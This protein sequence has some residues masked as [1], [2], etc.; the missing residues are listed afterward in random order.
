MHA[1]YHE[2]EEEYP[3]KWNNLISSLKVQAR[4]GKADPII[5]DIVYDSRKVT[6]G[7]VYVS[8][9]G[10]VVHGDQFIA[11]AMEQGAVAVIS[12]NPQLA[13]TVPWIQVENSRIVL[14][15]LARKLWNM[16]LYNTMLVGVTGT[17]GKTTVA[18]LY[19]KLL[20]EL[21]RNKD[22]WMFSTVGYSMGK[23][24]QD[25]HRTTPESSD[26]FRL[27]GKA[28]EKPAAL[29]MEVSS[30]ALHLNRVAGFS[31][32]IGVWTNLTQDHLDFHHNM[33]EYYEAKKKLFTT[34]LKSKGKAIINIDD[35]YG[36]MLSRELEGVKQITFGTSHDATVRIVNWK[37]DWSGSEIDI[38]TKGE[39]I[40][41]RSCLVGFFNVYNMAALAAGAI[42][43]SVS[44]RRVQK[45]LDKL[46]PVPG[47]MQQV[48]VDADFQVVV[49]YA[50]TPDALE[51]VLSTTRE[52]TKG[53]VICVFGCGGDRDK[54]KRPLMA[55]AVVAG[56]DEAVITSDNPRIENPMD[57]I[58]DILDGVPLDFP[59]W[60]IPDRKEG[61]AC[62]IELARPGDCIVV[63]GKGHENYQ[64][65]YGVRHPF[66]DKV[67]IGEIFEGRQETRAHA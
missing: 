60:V 34:Y 62:A 36:R 50:H 52:L 58:D 12:Q 30:H 24:G 13:C 3:V 46:T 63:A 25:A 37:C 28:D 51:N 64:E 17:N 18:Y 11:Q 49:D 4:G 9:P 7:C 39:I 44:P 33:T 8:I 43:M 67:V 22:V 19:R 6:P 42:A 15:E 65:I 38:I 47:R 35:E 41:F 53:R 21:N 57:I 5:A 10:M 23:A 2:P 48:P 59:H 56:A 27:I 26:I 55:E 1:G 54:T 14:G 31:Y 66:D 29:V 40:H 45:A 32:D 16:K 20:E 61:I